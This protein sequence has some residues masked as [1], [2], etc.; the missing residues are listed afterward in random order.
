MTARGWIRLACAKRASATMT[1]ARI[2]A[3]LVA[4]AA[5]FAP[6][7]SARAQT[8]SPSDLWNS[9]SSAWQDLPTC[10]AACADGAGCFA[11]FAITGA[12]AT[13]DAGNQN[14]AN[15]AQ[16]FCSAVANISTGSG[17]LDTI[18]NDLGAV[19][20]ESVVQSITSAL[21]SV[22]SPLAAA[23]CACDEVKDIGNVIQDVAD[24]VVAGLCDVT[25]LFGGA[26]GCTE[27]PTTVAANC[28][29]ILDNCQP[30]FIYDL[31]KCNDPNNNDLPCQC[32]R[33]G[34]VTR[35][36]DGTSPPYI[37][38]NTPGGTEI[39]QSNSGSAAFG[40]C[41]V[42]L[43]CFCPKP[44]TLQHKCDGIV[45]PG[46]GNNYELWYCQC[47]SGTDPDPSGKQVCLCPDGKPILSEPGA[48]ADLPCPGPLLG[49]PCPNGQIRYGDK[50]VTPCAKNEVMTPD[51]ACCDPSHVT[52]CGTCCPPGTT[53]N[54][55][56]G[57]C[58]PPQ[59]IQ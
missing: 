34:I 27:P 32:A 37:I 18:T 49:E 16:S 7:V 48:T 55:S 20:P 45:D 30:F 2:W 56:T 21:S 40:T 23:Q 11:A 42:S 22:A 9:I 57:T 8:C 41:G 47:P 38:I 5:T 33:A 29:P 46:C 24:C 39:I 10:A 43:T 17:D 19:L 28:A 1:S 53:P 14:T 31:N 50:C 15:A 36:G 51:G 58:Y 12:L 13:A 4:A 54:L 6:V 26:C 44:M 59:Q 25:E 52:S 3:V 35:S